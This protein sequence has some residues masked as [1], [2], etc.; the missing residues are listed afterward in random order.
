[1]TRP[2]VVSD[3]LMFVD[4]LK[5]R[6]ESI[7]DA[8]RAADTIK[9]HNCFC[10]ILFLSDH[11][12]DDPPLEKKA[13]KTQKDAQFLKDCTGW[14]LKKSNKWLNWRQREKN[15]LE[16]G[17]FGKKTRFQLRYARFTLIWTLPTQSNPCNDKTFP[18]ISLTN[19]TPCLLCFVIPFDS[20]WRNDFLGPKKN[21][22]VQD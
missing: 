17:T 19:R 10:Y 12:D 2:K 13:H 20:K 7:M 1:M 9:Q 22:Q 16:K 6:A 11:N 18:K 3:M 8:G 14:G 21:K 5:C 4:S 15:L